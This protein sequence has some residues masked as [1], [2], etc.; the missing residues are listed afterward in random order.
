MITL[1]SGNVKCKINKIF[2]NKTMQVI[3]S[4]LIFFGS[5]LR[6]MFL[7]NLS[8]KLDINGF[9]MCKPTGNSLVTD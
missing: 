1:P 6:L 9:T 8:E 7:L 4:K 2:L 3:L 5:K